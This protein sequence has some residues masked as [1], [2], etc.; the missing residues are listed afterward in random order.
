[1][2]NT[3]FIKKYIKG[4]TKGG[5]YCHL[6]FKDNILINYSTVIC[7]IDRKNKKAKVNSKKYSISTTKIQ[8]TLIRI[9]NQYG[10]NIEEYEGESANWW[11]FGYT[12]AERVTKEDLNYLI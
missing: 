11:N 1:M 2:N 4:D 3:D 6:G 9:L 5:V 12:G 7:T 8:N 10:Y